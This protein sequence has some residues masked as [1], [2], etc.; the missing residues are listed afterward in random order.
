M[1]SWRRWF[2]GKVQKRTPSEDDQQEVQEATNPRRGQSDECRL[3]LGKN[4]H[5]RGQIEREADRAIDDAGHGG[6]MPS[7]PQQSSQDC[8]NDNQID[9]PTELPRSRC[10]NT[11]QAESQQERHEGICMAHGVDDTEALRSRQLELVVP[12]DRML[13]WIVGS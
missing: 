13:G 11:Q 4:L 8:R 2:L 7:S 5:G 9:H 6:P 3:I 12:S 1:G 10:H